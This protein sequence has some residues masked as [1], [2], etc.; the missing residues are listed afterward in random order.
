MLKDQFLIALVTFLG[1]LANLNVATKNIE[2]K[3]DYFDYCI[4]RNTAH[5]L[6]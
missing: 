4:R 2:K 3:A 6:L 5:W 1:L